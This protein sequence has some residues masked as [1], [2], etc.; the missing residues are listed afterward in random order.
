MDNTNYTSK[1]SFKIIDE[2]Q[3][4]LFKFEKFRKDSNN[5]NFEQGRKRFMSFN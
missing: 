4:K 2:S 3:D 1:P 5:Y